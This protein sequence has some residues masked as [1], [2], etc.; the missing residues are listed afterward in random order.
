MVGAT[1]VPDED[2]GA[3]VHAK[4]PQ[5]GPA[6]H[7]VGFTPSGLEGGDGRV[8]Q[9]PHAHRFEVVRQQLPDT[10]QVAHT[11]VP[12][13]QVAPHQEAGLGARLG[14]LA[15]GETGAVW[16]TTGATSVRHFMSEAVVA[17]RDRHPGAVLEFRT[18]TSG[19][20][21]F[22]ALA[23]GAVA[24]AWVTIG[25]PVRGVGQRTL[26][27]LPWALAVRADDPLARGSRITPADL[28]GGGH[29]RL[30]ENSSS[31]T[32]LDTA[33]A[34]LGVR[35]TS[36]TGVADRDT[37]I[38]LAGLGMGRAVV[39][40]LPGQAATGRVRFLP[41]PELPPLPVGWALRRWTALN[42][43]ARS[44]ADLIEEQHGAA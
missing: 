11:L 19:R 39:P 4:F 16:V 12:L 23:E 13:G 10:R 15:R 21:C 8:E 26:M 40:T 38:L 44:F 9:L 24:L 41:L 14:E 6:D 30:P 34:R 36:D 3:R 37:A 1:G 25:T 7:G 42:P 5:R 32:H 27:E 28:A 22:D 35:L 33:F 31:R 17:F 2:G 43:L 18:E 20:N 29:I